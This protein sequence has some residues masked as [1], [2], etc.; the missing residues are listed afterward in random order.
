M[1]ISGWNFD[2]T[3]LPYWN[4]RDS[5]YCED[6]LFESP[7]SEYACLIYSVTEVRMLSYYG[8]CAVFDN[9]ENPSLILNIKYVNFEPYAYFSKD[10]ELLFLKATYRYGKQFILVLNLKKKVFSVVHFCAPL[11]YDIL[12]KNDGVFE[13]VFD[14]KT[15]QSD[16]RAKQISDTCIKLKD[17]RWRSWKILEDG[18]NLNLQNRN[19]WNLFKSANKIWEESLKK[20]SLGQMSSQE[21]IDQNRNKILY[22][23]LPFDTKENGKSVFSPMKN[24]TLEGDFFPAFTTIEFCKDY[25]EK[26]GRG[27]HVIIKGKLK[28]IM[29]SLDSHY[30][31][32]HWGVVIDPYNDFVGIPPGMRITPKSLRY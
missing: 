30:L 29:K 10:G 28:D 2:F 25:L 6:H 7:N 32:R 13:I 9:K 17:M 19:F 18:G 12:Q 3:T 31:L 16:S 21:F 27:P 5:V 24:S 8:F 4:N 14:E 26:S 20:F 1:N 23:C 11:Y 15:M 22:Y